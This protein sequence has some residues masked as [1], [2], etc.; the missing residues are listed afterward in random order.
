MGKEPEVLEAIL[1]A[2]LTEGFVVSPLGQ[3]GFRRDVPAFTRDHEEHFM[4]NST[5]RSPAR[6]LSI[7]AIAT[8]GRRLHSALTQS[9]TGYIG[10]NCLN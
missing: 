2:A 7:V 1:L 8:L 9:E 5:K 6:P 4:P 3:Q 10:K